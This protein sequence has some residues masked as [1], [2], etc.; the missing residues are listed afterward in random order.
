M[1]ESCHLDSDHFNW[2]LNHYDSAAFLY[3]KSISNL[4]VKPSIS[5]ILTYQ[6]DDMTASW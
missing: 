1:F 5:E 4:A 3:P 6:H 2:P